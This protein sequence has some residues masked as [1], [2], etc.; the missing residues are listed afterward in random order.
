VLRKGPRGGGRYRD[1]IADHVI[2]RSAWHVFDHA[3][4]IED[5]S[6]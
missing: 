2:R 6:T 4:E 1:R 5:K 3:W